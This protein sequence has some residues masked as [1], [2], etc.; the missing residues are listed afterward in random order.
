MAAYKRGKIWYI[1]YYYQGRRIRE[2]VGPS[3]R[4]AEQALTA[5]KGE[6]AQGKFDLD[7]I[8]SR[9]MFIDFAKTYLDYSEANK[10]S[11]KRDRTSIKALSR[12]FGDKRLSQITPWLIE[13]YKRKRKKQVMPS[14][15]NRELACLKHMYS[16]AIK[17]GDFDENPVKKVKFFRES[18]RRL[19]YLSEEEEARLLNSCNDHL[20]SIVITALNTGMRVSEILSLKWECVDFDLGIITVVNSKNNES[21]NIPLNTVLTEELHRL[22]LNAKNEYVFSRS[23]GQVTLSIRTAW[24]KALKRTNIQDF[25]FHDLRHT[26]ASKLVMAG[27]DIVTVKE[28]LGHKT[29]SVTMRYSHLSQEHKKKAVELLGGHNMVTKAK[30]ALIKTS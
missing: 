15:V 7:R 5:R 13:K 21:R 3:K 18:N 25:R 28:L 8:Q 9:P 29:I 24:E 22:R 17:W 20:R 30:Q 10:L 12:E 19:R 4:L 27:V 26:F 6:I 16:M 14:T 1:D 23:N 2:R 11:W